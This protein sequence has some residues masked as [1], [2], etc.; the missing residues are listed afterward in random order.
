MIEGTL[1]TVLI[2]NR[3]FERVTPEKCAAGRGK[4]LGELCGGGGRK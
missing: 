1:V 3:I 4:A 2:R